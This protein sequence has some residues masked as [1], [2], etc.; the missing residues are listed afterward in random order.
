MSHNKPFKGDVRIFPNSSLRKLSR[1]MRRGLVPSERQ[2]VID[3][4]VEKA[5]G[6]R[7]AYLNSSPAK[8]AYINAQQRR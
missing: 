3:A 4:A 6:R 5:T 8:T 2:V 1:A 7:A